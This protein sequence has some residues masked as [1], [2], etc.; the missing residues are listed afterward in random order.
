MSH[1]RAALT[2][3][4]LFE[5]RSTLYAEIQRLVRQQSVL[6]GT[7]DTLR[8]Q[9]T[10]WQCLLASASGVHFIVFGL[11]RSIMDDDDAND[12][13]ALTNVPHTPPQHPRVLSFVIW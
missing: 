3:G 10:V 9:L 2:G 1:S 4:D 12:E 8:Q 11:S 7:Q 6:E 13:E 5:N